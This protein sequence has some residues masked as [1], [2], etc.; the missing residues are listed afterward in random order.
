MRFSALGTPS[1]AAD[2]FDT[3]TAAPEEEREMDVSLTYANQLKGLLAKADGK[4]KFVALL[5]YAA[6]F[7]AAGEP[8]AF[9]AAQ[10]S[11]SAARKPFRVFKPVEFL[12]PLVERP[13]K[14][15]GLGA[16]LAYV[17]VPPAEARASRENLRGWRAVKKQQRG[18]RARA[19]PQRST[20]ASKTLVV[21]HDEKDARKTHLPTYPPSSSLPPL[22][23]SS[24]G[25]FVPPNAHKQ[26]KAVGMALYVG[27]DHVVWATSAGVLSGADARAR[28]ERFQ[29]VSLWAWFVASVASA[30]A[31]TGD[32]TQALDE[33]S[34]VKRDSEDTD[35]DVDTDEA[36]LVAAA[37][38]RAHMGA[39]ATSAAQAFLALALLD[40]TSLS[41]RRVAALGVAVSLA[42]CAS[43]T[44]ARKSKTA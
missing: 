27:A 13:P 25:W 31:Q 19:F 29:K 30:A 9:L 43:L 41:K 18:S 37:K 5:Q 23:P 3:R 7:A 11:L 24:L 40:K 6:M 15:K 8:G 17:R 44:P 22:P 38:A 33:M 32:L 20:V 39:V 2:P 4:D 42:N 10:K 28:G 35:T 21:S 36:R 34:A 16:C 12:M 26:V 1:R 14:G